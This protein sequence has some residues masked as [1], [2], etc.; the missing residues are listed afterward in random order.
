MRL[1]SGDDSVPSHQL[2]GSFAQDEA[3]RAEDTARHSWLQWLEH[4]SMGNKEEQILKETFRDGREV[5]DKVE[6]LEIVLNQL[7]MKL[8]ELVPARAGSPDLKLKHLREPVRAS[9][10]YLNAAA[11]DLS[12]PP[13]HIHRPAPH[14]PT[15]LAAPA[16]QLAQPARAPVAPHI[17]PAT[18]QPEGAPNTGHGQLK[19][20]VNVVNVVNVVSRPPEPL[21]RQLPP[22]LRPIP[23]PKP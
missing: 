9:A 6:K 7:R 11:T 15:R 4:N 10:P 17:A 18:L 21:I 23:P 1:M 12:H 16:A 2:Q 19:K 3:G 22:L 5:R 8:D 13:T 14:P 20:C